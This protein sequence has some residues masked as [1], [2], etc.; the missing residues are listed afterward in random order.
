[1]CR[2]QSGKFLNQPDVIGVSEAA[3][4]ACLKRSRVSEIAPLDSTL[5]EHHTRGLP[6]PKRPRDPIQLGKNLLGVGVLWFASS[7][8]WFV[9]DSFWMP[10]GVFSPFVPGFANVVIRAEFVMSAAMAAAGI[11]VWRSASRELSLADYL[12]V[13]SCASI[14]V[15]CVFT[16]YEW[17]R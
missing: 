2:H 11:L 5:G 3:G 14:P 15:L 17:V 6:G 8:T 13:L 9:L 12:I 1:M 4:N 7:V 10:P 16:M